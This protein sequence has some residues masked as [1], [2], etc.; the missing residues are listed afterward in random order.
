MCARDA[1]RLATKTELASAAVAA[2][3]EGAQPRRSRQ[4][5]LAAR[6]LGLP[7][8]VAHVRAS[9]FD[10]DVHDNLS[11]WLSICMPE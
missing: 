1:G 9:D 11:C 8:H 6:E 3:D 2:L 7:L 4:P 10:G 5:M